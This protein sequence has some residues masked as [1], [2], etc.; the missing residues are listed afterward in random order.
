MAEVVCPHCNS[1]VLIELHT[2]SEF[3]CPLCRT[4]FFYEHDETSTEL[5]PGTAWLSPNIDIENEIELMDGKRAQAKGL[6]LFFGISAL[7]LI[8]FTI[9]GGAA[10]FLSCFIFIIGSTAMAAFFGQTDIKHGLYYNSS[11]GMLTC[12]STR[13][14]GFWYVDKQIHSDQLSRVELYTVYLGEHQGHKLILKLHGDGWM[15]RMPGYGFRT[16]L[17]EKLVGMDVN[18]RNS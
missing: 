8:P 5:S 17:F 9:L 4:D 11:T 12:I 2:G 16:K 6:G 1:E 15:Q 7:F 3:T 10:G 13:K 18:E 14:N